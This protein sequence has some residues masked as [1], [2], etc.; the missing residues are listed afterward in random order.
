[1]MAAALA[2][3]QGGGLGGLH[4]GSP[5]PAAVDHSV[6][7][8]VGAMRPAGLLEKLLRQIESGELSLPVPEQLP[9]RS[10]GREV[11]GVFHNKTRVDELT[12]LGSHQVQF[13]L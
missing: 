5:R 8:V 1:M 2:T 12:S 4:R 9:P 6:L 3:E 11:R 7:V 10:P 13:V